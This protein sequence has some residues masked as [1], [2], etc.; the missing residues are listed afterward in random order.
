MLSPLFRSSFAGMAEASFVA[1]LAFAAV[2]G[3][4]QPQAL[5]QLRSGKVERQ[6]YQ[7]PEASQSVENAPAI[8][9][10]SSNG[11][12][13]RLVSAGSSST[14]GKRVRTSRPA[15]V[16]TASYA[17]DSVGGESILDAPTET[18]NSSPVE[19]PE[20][21]AMS[22]VQHDSYSHG[23]VQTSDC[24]C[25]SC[26][27]FNLLAPTC[28]EACPPGCGPL[29]A[30]WY[31]M[32]IRGEAPL[33]WRRAAGPPPLVT[34]SPVGTAEGVAGEL[35]QGTTS[36]LLGGGRLNEDLNVGGRITLSTWIDPAEEFGVQL[37]YWNAG[38]QDDTFRFDSNSNAILA[39]PFFNTSVAG[40]FQNDALLVSFPN[41]LSG[42]VQ[43]DS[44]SSVEG[45]ELQLRR[46][47]YQDRFTRIDW[48]SGYQHVS[49]DEGLV[50]ASSTTDLTNNQSIS[51]QDNFFT[52]NSFHG[53]SYGFISTRNIACWKMETLFRLGL[54]NMRREVAIS[55]STTTTSAGAS[56]TTQQ[57][58]L[59][60]GTNS[61][62]F[63]DDTFIVIPEAGF[64]LAYTFRPGW[65]FTVG[66]NYMFIP[67]VAQA[68]QQIG[69][70]LAVNLSDPLTG[71]LD[72]AFSFD[73]RNYWL[74]SL[75]LGLQ[76][77][78]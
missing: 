77:R 29:M 8:E 66:Y 49:I 4:P 61:R 16:V 62:H 22:D 25:D 13:A 23:H 1:A 32:R 15:Q 70:N 33:Y 35:G 56:N 78:Y 48:I 19:S 24:G 18:L 31:R 68:S 74:H 64:T 17:Q 45:L 73:E 41:T 42:N 60:R 27:D 14:G 2:V 12:N 6:L 7:A 55:G 37:R 44:M 11:R 57:G 65:D 69:D 28:A 67:K 58:L 50:I 53:G 26:G 20:P 63:V 39:R 30:L 71:Q 3:V 34:T 72:P 38:D 40:A 21:L 5:G 51:V 75:G 52:E 76:V 10:A 43:V 59:A 46:R 47:L 9:P 36:T 54:G